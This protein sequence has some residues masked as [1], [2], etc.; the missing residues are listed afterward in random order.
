MADAAPSYDRLIENFLSWA[1]REENIRAAV[2]IGSRARTDHPADEWS[3]LDLLIVADD[4]RRLLERDEWLRT[5]GAP[6]ITF[7]EPTP[8]DGGFERRVLFAGGLDVDF[9][10]V[11]TDDVRLWIGN[12]LPPMAADILHRGVKVLVDKDG[13]AERMRA[14]AEPPATAAPPACSEFLNAVNDF[15]Y[16]AVWTAKHLR[17]GELWW[18]HSCCDVHL[19]NLL[20]RALEWHARSARTGID[21][22]MRGRFLEEWADPGALAD[23]PATFAR[24]E[25]EDVWRALRATMDLFARLAADAASR[26]KYPYPS[27]GEETARSLVE[28]YYAGRTVHDPT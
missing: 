9:A 28:A 5:I 16:H 27:A 12:S 4:P 21:T 18:A 8:G 14:G 10:P 20:R 19:K 22:W 23:L 25:T 3:D 17:R 24:H 1:K 13:L 2:I 7:L 26:W 11:S 6:R 15:W